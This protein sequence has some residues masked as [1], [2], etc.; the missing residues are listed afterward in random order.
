M[1]EATRTTQDEHMLAALAHASILLG[2]FTGGVGGLVAP[3]I[4]WL[5][6][7][8]KSAYVTA[9]ALQALVYQIATFVLNLL[10]W[11]GWT[12]LFLLL[13]LPPLISNPD[14]YEETPPSGMWIGLILML[15]P[16]GISLLT[17]L[18]GLWGGLRC[19]NGHDF[20]YI[21]IG[22]WLRHR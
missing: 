13:L 19:L 8:E 18:Y 10:V 11:L 6:Q 22:R 20:R 21:V 7:R 2:L 3:L 5:F 14:A 15:V 4:I 17:M 1:T 16:L 12:V 9:Q